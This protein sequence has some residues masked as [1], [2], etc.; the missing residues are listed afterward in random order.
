[1]SVDIISIVITT[2]TVLSGISGLIAI[3]IVIWDHFK[4]DRKLTK[5]VQRFYSLFNYKNNKN[6]ISLY[7]DINFNGVL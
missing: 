6:F 5:K 3:I 2:I 7:D 4:D 1:M